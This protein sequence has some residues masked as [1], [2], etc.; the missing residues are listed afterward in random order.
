MFHRVKSEADHG[1]QQA[2]ETQA[3]APQQEQTTQ[4]ASTDA[5]E[6]AQTPDLQA[7]QTQ[8]STTS[9]QTHSTSNKDTETMT[10]QA[11]TQAQ[12]T[13][14]QE[15]A[16]PSVGYSR[17]PVQPKYTSAYSSQMSYGRAPRAPETQ[18]EH[19][20]RT[21]TIGAGITMSGEI[22]SCDNLIVEGTVEAALKGAR[23]LDIAESGTFYG[24]VEIEQAEIAG[25][26]E[27]E[28]TVTGQL[29]LRAGGVITGSIA[30]G[31][32]EIEAG[33]IIDGRLTPV[34]AQQQ[35]E[36]AKPQ[37]RKA[38]AKATTAQDKQD[39]ANT[40]GELFAAVKA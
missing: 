14:Q 23:N 29:T 15:A 3:S 34:A 30:Y 21:L 18:A 26:F 35:A 4:A 33:A 1:A 22:E 24:T 40:D 37:Q 17:A 10:E 28:L 9:T 19:Q 6:V 32:L 13:S 5:A 25:R 36:Q 11:D 8:T 20:D 38:T 27:G 12:Q 31:S 16:Q 2:S 7:T 39:A